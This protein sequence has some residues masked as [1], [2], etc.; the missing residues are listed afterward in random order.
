MSFTIDKSLLLLLKQRYFTY[1][2]KELLSE[3]QEKRKI[4]PLPDE[5]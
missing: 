4:L 3:Q 5:C 2:F 1:A